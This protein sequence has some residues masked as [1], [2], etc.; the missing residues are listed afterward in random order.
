[1]A[2]IAQNDSWDVIAAQQDECGMAP[3]QLDSFNEFIESS[4]QDV[5]DGAPSFVCKAQNG[6]SQT[7]HTVQFKQLLIASPVTRETVDLPKDLYPNEARLRNLTYAAPLYA[8]VNVTIEHNAGTPTAERT[9]SEISQVFIGKM[10]IM[11]NSRFCRLY[12]K[13]AKQRIALGECD[14][15]PGGYF[16]VNG[17]EKVIIPNERMAT[18]Q[19]YVYP[20][21]Q[22]FKHSFIAEIRSGAEYSQKPPTTL[23]LALLSHSQRIEAVQ[24][25]YVK[26]PIPIVVLFRALGVITD[27]E[28]VE[29]TVYDITDREMTGCLTASIDAAIVV[30]S[31]EVALDYIGKCLL[32]QQPTREGRI[33]AARDVLRKEL[34]PHVAVDDGNERNKALYLGYMVNRL[35]AAK[36]GRRIIDDRDHYGNKRLDLAGPLLAVLFRQLFRQMTS[37]MRKAIQKKLQMG[38]VPNVVEAIKHSTITHGMKYAL[39]TGNWIGAKGGL[40]EGRVLNGVA[41]VL[42]RLTYASTLSHLRRVNTPVSKE[43]KLT[44]PRQMHNTHWNLICPVETPEGAACG[45]TKNLSF[46]AH[47]SVQNNAPSVRDFARSNIIPLDEVRPAEIAPFVKVFFN[48]EWLGTTD[49]A[50]VLMANLIDYRRRTAHVNG[51]A[52]FVFD[53]ISAEIR[54]FT[55]PGRGMRPLYVVTDGRLRINATHIEALR[56][57]RDTGRDGLTWS[58]LVTKQ[59][60]EYIDTNESETTMTALTMDDLT[61]QLR[62]RPGRSTRQF[63]HC[64]LHPSTILGICASSIPFPQHNQAPRNTY[65]TAMGKQSMGHYTNNY[66]LRFDSLANVLY[67]PQVPLV[68]TK[69]AELMRANEMPAGINAVVAIMCYTGFNQEDSV[70]M[71]QSAI[72]RGL[73]RSVFFRSYQDRERVDLRGPANKKT[74]VVLEEFGVPTLG[75]CTRADPRDFTKLDTDGLVRVGEHVHGKDVIIGKMALLP[76]KTNTSTAS[77]VRKSAATHRN[78]SQHLRAGENSIVDSVILT[79]NADGVKFTKVRTRSM[80]VPT[81]GDKFSSR[82][83]QKGTMGAAYRQEDM[84]FTI[85][86]ISP[87]IIVNPHAIPSR[88]TVGQLVE[89]IVGKTAAVTGS[90]ADGT[91]FGTATVDQFEQALHDCGYLRGGTEVLYDGHTGKRIEA[92]IFIGPTYYQRLK[93]MVDDKMHARARGPTSAL[94][95]QPLEGRGRDGGLRFGEMERDW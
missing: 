91:P 1:M 39:A 56:L 48:G 28:I 10:P 45:L 79:T 9:S 2:E 64:E 95:R 84:P 69:A 46:M 51:E 24:I 50:D 43:A 16:I 53:R 41:Q 54:I 25:P 61:E 12:G 40:G 88:M 13:S 75:K 63:T 78:I 89:T 57:R 94:V 33:R 19:V 72:D 37:D 36:L 90:I 6:N 65:Q 83:G 23:V 22:P 35:L 5:I 82:H 49:D 74:T 4:L 14:A 27:R 30:R 15:D 62:A 76:A 34:L 20:Q 17:G 73:F 52:S 44:K 47:I 58:D 29:M 92:K 70:L 31:T 80:R 59:L 11:V 93:H 7:I 85:E 87:D 67:Y 71:N 32:T 66:N 60:I 38:K 55:D 8:D 18:N 86:G 3:Q 26:S 42:N 21:R 77:G 81:V 68:G